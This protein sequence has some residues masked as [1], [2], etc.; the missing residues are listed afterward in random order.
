M[1]KFAVL[2]N[3]LGQGLGDIRKRPRQQYLHTAMQHICMATNHRT[4]ISFRLFMR[5]RLVN[6]HWSVVRSVLGVQRRCI[7]TQI[8]RSFFDGPSLGD[9]SNPIHPIFSPDGFV[10]PSI[11]Y[12]P[13]ENSLRLASRFL[14]TEEL[15]PFW[16]TVFHGPIE[17]ATAYPL[18]SPSERLARL[19]EQQKNEV[20][21]KL[22]F[23]SHCVTFASER[24]HWS[25][26]DTGYTERLLTD[27]P[28]PFRGVKTNVSISRR[29]FR[30]VEQSFS[31][32]YMDNHSR[33]W[34]HFLLANLL[35][36]ELAHA[37]MYAA[38][39][40]P[41][42]YDPIQAYFLPGA[43]TT[44]EG[45]EW[46]TSVFGGLLYEVPAFLFRKRERTVLGSK[47]VLREWPSP[48]LV[49]H[50]RKS[51]Y[52]R[53]F[54]VKGDLPQ[55]DRFWLVDPK[56]LERLFTTAFWEETLPRAGVT[57]LRPSCTECFVSRGPLGL[58]S[59]DAGCAKKRSLEPD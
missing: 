42:A 41:P 50:Y 7:F 35:L 24:T 57:V 55:L 56:F 16:Y 10:D 43:R 27:A 54:P 12:V 36:H 49:A 25:R 37:A 45:M 2:H 5:P 40:R 38:H 13:L 48:R 53:P 4:L 21:T 9:L 11:H 51:I 52:P 29:V 22:E 58:L 18:P 34:I 46:E 30:M 39:P 6:A 1:F 32:P 28:P 44:E 31:R 15:L 14:T 19:T 3:D 17:T 26:G 20:T 47:I 8:S 59:P 23:L 33:L